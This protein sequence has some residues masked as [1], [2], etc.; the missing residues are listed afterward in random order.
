MLHREI[1]GWEDANTHA[2][3]FTRGVGTLA[4]V[5]LAL[6]RPLAARSARPVA[7][8]RLVRVARG[9][10]RG[11]S[12]TFD[13]ARESQLDAGVPLFAEYKTRVTFYLTANDLS[14]SRRRVEAG[15]GCGP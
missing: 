10:R 3:R 8:R 14:R 4:A 7:R 13:D 15:G 2:G 6:R 5:T 11:L 9:R 12:L 1:V